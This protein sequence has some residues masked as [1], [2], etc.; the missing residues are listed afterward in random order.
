MTSPT[1][2]I[3]LTGATGYIGG[4]V[5]NDLLKNTQLGPITLLLRG[6]QSR[7]DK[8]KATYGSRIN[9][10]IYEGLDDIDATIAAASQHD[11]AINAAVGYHPPSAVALVRGLAQRKN[12]TGRDVWLIQTSGTSN[13]ADQPVS[14]KYVN[15]PADR[16]FDDAKDDVYAYEKAREASV[17]Y[18]QRSTELAAVDAGIE[19]GVKTIAI[20]SPSIFGTGTG[21]FHNKTFQIPLFIKAFLDHG[22]PFVIAGGKGVW[23]HVH[24]ED[25]GALYTV[26]VLEMVKDGGERIPSGKKGIVFSGNGRHTWGDIARGVGKALFEQGKVTEKDVQD[27]SLT[28]GTKVISPHMFGMPE[29]VVEVGVCSNARTLS[30]VARSLGWKPTRGAEA[31]EATF[32]SDVK[33]LLAEL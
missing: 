2:K 13:L 21:L 26:L 32:E 7:I 28:E 27:V 4:T 16:E 10:V 31:W 29:D 12:D 5:L 14:G 22:R 9:P 1:P 19:H 15:E 11:I 23:D 3:L 20:M 24:V 17:Q 25:L 33:D 30:N 6:S 8:L 18:F